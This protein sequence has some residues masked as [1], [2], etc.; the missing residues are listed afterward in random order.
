[1]SKLMPTIFVGHGNPMNSISHNAYTDSW[2]ALGQRLPRPSAILAI[3][4]HWYLPAC[5]VTDGLSP[6]TIHDFGGFPHELYAVQY[7]APG[8][9]ELARRVQALLAPIEVDRDES[10]GIDHGTWSVLVH[11][12]PQADIP[13]VQLSIDN[14]QP[15]EFHYELGKRLSVLREEGVLILGS[16]NLVHN[17]R[18]YAWGKEDCPPFDWATRFEQRVKDL[19]IKQDDSL[20]VD[21]KRLGE[22][23]RLSIP[24]P[25]HYLP[26]LYVLGARRP[27]ETISFPTNG[28]DGGSVSML[29]MQWG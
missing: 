25:E 11:I 6:R 17:L 28:I 21:Y 16:G 2:V 24:T 27:D 14:R 29:A 22:D 1:M 9:P 13:T 3:S 23:A 12:F 7:P 18:T 20:L 15:P 4:A 5:A 26:L 19:L 8:S 10:W